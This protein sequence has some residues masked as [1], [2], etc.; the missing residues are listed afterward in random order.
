[1]FAM[2]HFL[3]FLVVSVPAVFAFL[4]FC[5]FFFLLLLVCLH[6]FSVTMITNL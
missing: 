3:C 2:Q 5:F 1:M 6:S 4:F